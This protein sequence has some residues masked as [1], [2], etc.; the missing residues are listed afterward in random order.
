[1]SHKVQQLW[2]AGLKL[3]MPQYFKQVQ[4]L[5][6]GSLNVNGTL[7]DLFIDCEYTGVDVIPGKDV[8]IVGTFHE[9]DFGDKVFDVVCSVNSLEHDIHFDKTLPRMYQLLRHGG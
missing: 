3:A 9:I 8:D 7:R 2:C 4:V 5:E 1:M 6:M